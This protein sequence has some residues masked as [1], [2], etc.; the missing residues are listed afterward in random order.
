MDCPKCLYGLPK[1]HKN[2]IPLRP[3]LSA[4]KSHSYSLAKF[5]VSL[6]C[7]LA[8]NQY[9]ILLYILNLFF[10][11]AMLMT[12]LYCLTHNFFLKIIYFDEYSC[13]IY[14]SFALSSYFLFYVTISAKICD[15]IDYSNFSNFHS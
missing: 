5:L 4:I 12:R 6:L 3:I 14:H 11:A 10:S 15:N 7:P 9:T 8:T 13:K 2:G 1:I